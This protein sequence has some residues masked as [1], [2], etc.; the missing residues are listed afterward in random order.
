MIV[1]VGN[2]L[3]GELLIRYT[4]YIIRGGNPIGISNLNAQCQR[5]YCI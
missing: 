5:L 2:G 4:F 1:V 3:M